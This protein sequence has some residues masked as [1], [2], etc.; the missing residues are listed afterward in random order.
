M[1]NW[2]QGKKTYILSGI[3]AVYVAGQM[4]S[5]S[6]DMQTGVMEILGCLGF[7]TVRHGVSTSGD[8]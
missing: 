4:W 8:K 3:G 7:S 1:W 6:V 2:L 5:G